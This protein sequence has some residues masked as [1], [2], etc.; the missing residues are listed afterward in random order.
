[1]MDFQTFSSIG[2]VLPICALDPR[3]LT[4]LPEML[5]HVFLACKPSY[6]CCYQML[7]PVS[8]MCLVGNRMAT[9][10]C[11]WVIFDIQLYSRQCL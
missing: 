1:M 4:I 6:T 7:S 8:T 5:Q 10:P 3:L 9:G 2:L 11:S